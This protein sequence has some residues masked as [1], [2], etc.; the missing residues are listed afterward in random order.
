[1]I[2]SALTLLL[3]FAK[4]IA[5]LHHCRNVVPPPGVWG[6]GENSWRGRLGNASRPFWWV[7]A[8]TS[9]YGEEGYETDS[10]G[11][12]AADGDQRLHPL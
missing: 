8:E 11:P 4:C 5:E 1:M 2:L 12:G 7:V 6:V 3:A 10:G 9:S